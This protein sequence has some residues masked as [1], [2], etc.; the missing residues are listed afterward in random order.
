MA[1]EPKSESAS[2]I[3]DVP[4]DVS[5]TKSDTN[6]AVADVKVG[7]AAEPHKQ[8]AF[9]KAFLRSVPILGTSAPC[10]AAMW[11]PILMHAHISYHPICVKCFAGN[12]LCER[13]AYYGISVSP[14]GACGGPGLHPCFPS[15]P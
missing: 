8:P 1:D 12:E 15:S 13:L 3:K 11:D 5:D 2:P 4:V 10:I 6:D 14:E 9:G 7:G